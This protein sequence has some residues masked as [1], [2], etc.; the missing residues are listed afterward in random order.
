MYHYMSTWT[1]LQNMTIDEGL[2]QEERGNGLRSFRKKI[3][4]QGG[5]CDF[6]LITHVTHHHK[7]TQK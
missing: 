5:G 2:Q 4:I 6:M 7:Y 3:H 1:F